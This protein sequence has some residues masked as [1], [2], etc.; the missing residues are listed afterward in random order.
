MLNFP[1]LNKPFYLQ[2]DASNFAIG[3]VLYQIDASGDIKIIASGSRTLRGYEVAFFT[4]EKELLAL[5][6][7][8]QKYRNFLWGA[9]IIHRTDHMA[10]SFLRSCKLL[11]QRSTRW[12][13]AIQDY[14]IKAEFCIGKEKVMA[15]AIIRF[16][17]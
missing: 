8:L 5:V 3:A 16:T 11:N 15:D 7:A 12:I 4:T 14:Q 9:S 10:L 13:M 2:T 6:W 1:D 17:T